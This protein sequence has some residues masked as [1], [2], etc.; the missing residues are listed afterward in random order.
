MPDATP[1]SGTCLPAPSAQGLE[2][3]WANVHSH[4]IHTNQEVQQL[5]PQTEEQ[6][7]E[8][9]WKQGGILVI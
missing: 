5:T 3:V 6:T 7:L 9:V 2:H 8:T 1:A 4:T